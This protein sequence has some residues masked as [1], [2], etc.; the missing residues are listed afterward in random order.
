VERAPHHEEQ[1]ADSRANGRNGAIELCFEMLAAG[2]R[3][4]EVLAELA[5]NP[6]MLAD[7]SPV[8]DFCNGEANQPLDHGGAAI[9]KEQIRAAIDRMILETESVARSETTASEDSRDSPSDRS[10]PA[11]HS[12]HDHVGSRLIRAGRDRVARL[13]TAAQGGASRPVATLVVCGALIVAASGAA[14]LIGGAATPQQPRRTGSATIGSPDRVAVAIP[15]TRRL[16]VSQAS[17][18]GPIASSRPTRSPPERRQVPL[19]PHQNAPTSPQRS[20]ASAASIAASPA[21]AEQRETAAAHAPPQSPAKPAVIGS[22]AMTP[23][24]PSDPTAASLPASEVSGMSSRGD[25]LLASGDVTSA[26][27]FYLRGAEGG[28]GPAALRLGETFDPAFLSQAGL[29]RSASDT[30]KAAY[31]YRRAHDLG[32]R[33]AAFLL[34]QIGPSKQR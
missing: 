32:V 29:P 16:T 6:G 4:D 9:T 21:A 18:S 25:E 1:N 11:A 12:P 8:P 22:G 17:A 13:M 31:W 14:W 3:L 7:R 23:P 15:A 24:P 28:N 19:S 27:L 20:I 26:R 30:T 10:L 33:G 5:A 2:R 34:K